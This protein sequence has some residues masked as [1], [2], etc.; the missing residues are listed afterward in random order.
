MPVPGDVEGRR[1]PGPNGSAGM[2]VQVLVV[3]DEP[4]ARL[5]LRTLLAACDTP[6]ADVVGEA[7]NA[8]QALE[9]LGRR[10]IDAI[11]QDVQMPGADGVSFAR[12]LREMPNP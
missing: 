12:A 2:T 6:P 9:L 7:A 1:V 4:L 8:A 3:D 5:R 11:L 10:N